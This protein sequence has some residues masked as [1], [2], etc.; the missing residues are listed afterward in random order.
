MATASATGLAGSRNPKESGLVGSR[1]PKESGLGGLR[2]PK[3]SGLAGSRNPK[4]WLQRD[5]ALL[6]NLPQASS[7]HSFFGCLYPK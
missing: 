1:N 4:E 6:Q 3:E 7:I 2:N 5:L